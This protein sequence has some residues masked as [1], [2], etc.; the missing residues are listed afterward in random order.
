[1]ET[2]HCRVCGYKLPFLP[3]GEDGCTPTYEICPCCGVEFGNE[4]Y[5]E[6]AIQNYRENWISA[7]CPW[8][9]P[10]KK[11]LQWSLD[12]QLKNVPISFK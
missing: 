4:D 6:N 2:A 8:F 5:S 1:M 9:N 11:P 3:W 12:E 7:R 10:Q